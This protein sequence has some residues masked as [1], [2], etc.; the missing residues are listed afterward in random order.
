VDS[1]LGEGDMTVGTQDPAQGLNDDMPG[2]LRQVGEL[3]VHGHASTDARLD[4]LE[5]GQAST[6]AR[7]DRLERG[8]ARTDARLDRL[9]GDM[10]ELKTGLA[11][12]N[13]RLDRSELANERRANR[14]DAQ[15]ERLVALIERDEHKS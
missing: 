1:D 5:R 4:R 7:L 12:T 6:D 15:F 9:E 10:A 3:I 13:E 8:Q 2:L 11:Q 14:V